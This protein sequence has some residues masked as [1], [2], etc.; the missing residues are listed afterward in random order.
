[1]ATDQTSSDLKNASSSSCTS[2]FDNS[3]SNVS[4]YVRHDVF[5]DVFEV[6]SKYVPPI[7]PIGRGYYG[8]LCSAVNA[9][10]GEKVAIKKICDAFDSRINA[11]RIL[12]E[13]KL[14]QSM[15]HENIIAIKDIIR[16]PKREDFRDVYIVYDLMDTDLHQ[17]I[18]SDQKLTDDHIQYF[19]YQILRGLKYVQSANVLHCGLKPN[20]IFLNANCDLKIGSFG[21]ARTDSDTDFMKA[22]GIITHYWA[23]EVLLNR[24]AYSA[25]ADIWSVGCIFGEMM[26]KTPLFPRR[27]YVHHLELITELL[28][29]PDYASLEFLQSDNAL[30]IFEQ[31]PQ[32]PKQ[33]LRDR[34]PN[35]SPL[36][37]DLL[38]K[39]L[40]FEPNKR[41]TGK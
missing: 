19:L 12:K 31:L 2:D 7:S 11:R 14:L 26:T 13:I 29:T 1:M 28:G 18:R 35:R 40:V 16:P 8:L 33:Q 25:A 3:N 23:P 36:A 17:V 5:G 20:T 30:R 41:I 4:P 10:T 15:D 24:S 21:M 37:I 9:E 34:F 22:Y 32:Y 38:E 6:P 39:M 27:D